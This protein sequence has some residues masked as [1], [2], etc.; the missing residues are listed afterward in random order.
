MFKK[1]SAYV[2]PV[3]VLLFLSLI[4]TAST[5]GTRVDAQDSDKTQQQTVYIHTIQSENGKLSITADEINWY[6]GA[7]ADRV[8]AERDP[9]GAA[10]IGGAPDGYY[11]VNDV[12]TL[13]TYPIAD[14]ATVTMQIYDHTGNIDD[15][16]I[17]WNE[18]ITLQQFIDQFNNT[19]ILDLSQFPYHLTIQ[20]GVI[21]S[22]V[23]QY[24]P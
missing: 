6:Q 15:L 13:T 10:E 7:D 8:F 17:Q 23:Q 14:N 16:D 18:A 2:L 1:K 11:V 24:I 4:T 19:D 21:T 20:D 12:D 5:V 3:V 9:E 22:I